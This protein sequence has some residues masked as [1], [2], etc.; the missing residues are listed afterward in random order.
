[1]KNLFFTILIITYGQALFSQ[2]DMSVGFTALEK[3][4]FNQ[5][6]I[7][8]EEILSNE[9]NNKTAQIC[10]NRALG[11]NGKPEKANQN[12]KNLLVTY[13]KDQEIELNYLE[14]FLWAKQ[15]IEAK[16]LYKD[17][18]GRH[19]KNFSAVLGYANTLS[20]LKDYDSALI[21]V[22]KA[23][24]IQPKNNSAAVSKKYILLGRANTLI[25]NQD[26]TTAEQTLIS[27]LSDFHEDKDVLQNLA[28]LYLISKEVEKAKSTYKRFAT[29]EKDSVTAFN[30][31][32]LAEHIGG[33]DSKA[34]KIATINLEHAENVGDFELIERTQNRYIQALIW[35]RKFVKARKI[36]DNLHDKYPNRD[37]I[38]ALRATLGLYTGSPKNSI[39]DYNIILAQDSSSFDGNLG[40]AN[41]LF[42]SDKINAAYNAAQKTL[43]F[44]PKQKDAEQFIEKIDGMFIPNISEKAG[45]TF[46]NGNNVAIFSNTTVEVPFSTKFRANATYGYRD[47][48][49][50]V[51]GSNAYTHTLVMGLDYKLLPKTTI[52]GTFGFNKS[53]FRDDFYTQPILDLKLLLQPLKLQNISLGYQREIQNFNAD[54]IAQ[55]IIQDNY[56][57]NYNL[58]TNFGLGWF[59]QVIHT[60][61]SDA[62]QRDLLFTSLYY[63]LFQ[64]PALKLG[65][66]YQYITFKDQ[67]PALYFSPE[68][69]QAIELFGDL[70]LALSDKMQLSASAA[71]GQQKV[72]DDPFTPIF[73]AEIDYNYQMSKRFS[74]G[75]YGKYSNIASATAAGF[76]FAEIGLKLRWSMTAKPLFKRG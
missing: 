24:D 62:N 54:L 72:E 33:D 30:G 50:T 6:E 37:W 47:T 9:P 8:F 70:R 11:L 15:F 41:A 59:T 58:G 20:N 18:L 36:I 49:N 69:Y 39:A 5:A 55:E 1:M 4:E 22:N 14:S 43:F 23:L 48:E 71:L 31:I 73:R 56:L 74:G 60:E 28:N 2:S 76:E 51:S 65:V 21:W 26:Y 68:I 25:N 13:P 57:L 63:S 27:I 34:L 19:P 45:Y 42:A 40:K 12:F 66:N 52:K 75:L 64:K 53:G 67:V 10:Y 3:G 29:N 38:L 35:N 61:Q 16:P 17:F 44:Y 46:D 32:A 7:F